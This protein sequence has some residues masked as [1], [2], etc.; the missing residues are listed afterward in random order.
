MP[1]LGGTDL[2]GFSNYRFRDRHSIWFT[3]EYR[4]YV[5]EFVDMAVFYDAGKV[6]PERS[7]LDFD[8]LKTSI[9]AGIRF[10]GPRTTA[11]RFEVARSAEGWRLIFGFSPAGGR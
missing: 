7:Q 6:A 8:D 11:V 1:Q 9:G 4:W 3:G 5:Q 2:R 10:H